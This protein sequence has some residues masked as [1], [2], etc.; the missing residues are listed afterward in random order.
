MND[1]SC[2]NQQKN[3]PP[4][5]LLALGISLV[6]YIF[7]Q[8]GLFESSVYY[9]GIIL[10]IAGGIQIMIGLR[11]QQQG[12]S[13]AAAILLPFGFFWLSII[14]YEIFPRLGFGQ[15]PGSTAMF[16]YL[17]MWAMF[18]AIQ[19]LGSFRQNLTMQYLYG[20]MMV[21]LL[22]LSIDQLR[23]D[24]VF[25]AIGCVFGVVAA[26]VAISTAL[27]QFSEQWTGRYHRAVPH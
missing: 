11:S 27:T 23:E 25:L 26:F 7:C 22:S 6:A 1:N 3:L 20:T 13:Y 8:A 4:C 9:S 15:H 21:C 12:N 2:S 19:F 16:A 14:G 18:V 5:G 24:Q 17:T 10:L